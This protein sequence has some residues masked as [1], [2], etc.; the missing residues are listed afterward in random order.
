MRDLFPALQANPNLIYLDSAASSLIC[1]PALE[2]VDNYYRTNGANVHR[3]LYELSERATSVYEAARQKV[4]HLINAETDEIIFTKNTTESINQLAFGIENSFL[5]YEIWLDPTSHHANLLPW[6]RLADR[7]NR[8]PK[9]LSIT[10]GMMINWPEAF[11][12]LDD[13]KV[14]IA[15]NHAS[16]VLGN[17]NDIEKISNQ[18]RKVCRE[19]LIFVDGAQ[20]I[21]HIKVDIKK[22]NIDGY[23]FSS[24]KMYGPKG[25]GAMWINRKLHDT[26]EPM[27]V[28]GGSILEVT[29]DSVTYLKSP[30]KF[31]AGTPAIAE[32]I[33]FGEAAEF[34]NAQ[35]MSNDLADYLWQS[36]SDIPGVRLIGTSGDRV[37]LVAVCHDK[38]HAHDLSAWLAE[39]NLATRAG[40]H[41]A[42]PLHQRLHMPASLRFSAGIYNTR[43]DI[44]SARQQLQKAI[45]ILG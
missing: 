26:L 42:M 33:G 15:I 39:Q 29:D 3:G 43:E 9:L 1:Q 14:I 24:H 37:P 4:A 31:E 25:V 2:A 18:L 17:I 7:T 45:E 16:N 21:P 22:L 35:E 41:C 28:G 44:D 12:N 40:H 23:S 36:F 10:D 34:L 38:I 19:V 6:R 27:L 5:D 8:Q 13:K 20:A 32:V 30:A 11:K